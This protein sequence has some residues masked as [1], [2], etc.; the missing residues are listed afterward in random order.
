MF[1]TVFA[2]S[3]RKFAWAVELPTLNCES[4]KDLLGIYHF[5]KM[6]KGSY[7]YQNRIE[8]GCVL[9]RQENV[10]EDK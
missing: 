4:V 8:V 6:R 5:A 3:L 9:I 2:L 10:E 7:F 1:D